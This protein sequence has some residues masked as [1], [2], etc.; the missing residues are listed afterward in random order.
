MAVDHLMCHSAGVSLRSAHAAVER[1]TD[2]KGFEEC[3]K[4][5]F[6]SVYPVLESTS[7]FRDLTLDVATE[8]RR[9]LAAVVDRF[10]IDAVL[11]ESRQML[12][13]AVV[14]HVPQQRC[15]LLNRVFPDRFRPHWCF[16][17]FISDRACVR[18]WTS[19]LTSPASMDA[20]TWRFLLMKMDQWN[21]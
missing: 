2:V 14:C 17:L 9:L 10:H 16:T 12:S 3:L 7:A 13:A 4:E 1:S 8:R 21:G 5:G 20:F 19:A 6:P 11:G 15:R 18:S